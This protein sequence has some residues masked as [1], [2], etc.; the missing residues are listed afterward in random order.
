MIGPSDLRA[1]GAILFGDQHQQRELWGIYAMGTKGFVIDGGNHPRDPPGA[2]QQAGLRYFAYQAC[3]RRVGLIPFHVAHV[4]YVQ[5]IVKA[6]IAAL[7]RSAV[8]ITNRAMLPPYA[9]RLIPHDPQWAEQASQEEARILKAVWPALIEMHHVGST[10]IPGIAAKPIIDLVGVTPSLD[11]LEDARPMLEQLGYAWHGEFGLA[12]R[13]FCTLSDPL[14]GQR[15]FHLHCYASGDHSI[16][17]HLAFRDYLRA[18]PAVAEAYQTMKQACAAK[19]PDD[20]HAYTECK[21]RW[22]K[23]VEAEALKLF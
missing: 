18:R 9:V 5:H 21:D 3:D 1:A 22:I 23:R 4:L 11:A 13:R 20:S 14:S 10:A 19:H 7:K 16:H 17:R 2:G 8:A 6:Y 15:R 12:G